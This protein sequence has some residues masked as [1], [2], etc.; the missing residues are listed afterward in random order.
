MS[1]SVTDVKEIKVDSVDGIVEILQAI[2]RNDRSNYRHHEPRPWDDRRPDVE[3][4]TIWLTPKEL[5]TRALRR[6]G[7]A[8]PDRLKEVYRS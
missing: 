6:M 2:V 7:A 8:V 4:G 5:A 1:D 3:G